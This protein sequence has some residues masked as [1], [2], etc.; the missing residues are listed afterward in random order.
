MG[1]KKAEILHEVFAKREATQAVEQF[2]IEHRI[3]PRLAHR[4]FEKYENRAVEVISK[5][6][7]VLARVL[8]GVGFLTADT[9]ALNLNFA[10][11]SPERIKAGLSYAL[12]K[13]SDDGHCYLT[14]SDLAL[15]TRTL[16]DLSESVDLTPYI[17]GLIREGEL[18]K[19]GD[20]LLLESIDRSEQYVAE[21]IAARCTPF[22]NET[23]NPLTAERSLREAEKSLN[24]V[25]SPE[26]RQ[27]VMNAIR[28]PLSIITGGPGCGKTT[29]IKALSHLYK[30]NNLQVRFIG[31]LNLTPKTVNSNTTPKIH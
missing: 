17:E 6:P 31:Y 12:E 15:K 16:L 18:V 20:A 13:A 28:F 5:D 11:D 9:I 30:E 22:P 14:E 23:V 1:K 4:I 25:F 24:V 27:A 21:F 29:I 2:L 7:Y 26:Q 19:D 3:S 10:P 8:R